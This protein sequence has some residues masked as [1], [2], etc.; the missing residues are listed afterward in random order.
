MGRVSAYIGPMKTLAPLAVCLAL[1][2][3]IA[4]AE[5]EAEGKSLMEQGME[6]FFQGLREEMSP[7]LKDLQ[8]L[9][10]EFGP[11]MR[12]F[13]QEMGPAL[14]DIMDQVKDW[15][16]YDAPEILPNG[17]IIIRRKPDAPA[18]PDEEPPAGPTDI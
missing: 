7:A 1:V 9:T 18:L 16:R 5:D 14:G 3:P 17:D 2:A 12:G 15:S 13:F 10:E 4:H 6:M 8:N 11:Q